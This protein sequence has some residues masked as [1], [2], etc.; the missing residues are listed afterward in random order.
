MAGD[1]FGAIADPTRR[2]VF[3][4][5]ANA[6]P[7]TATALAADMEISRQAVAK[8]L[9]VL[10]DAGMAAGHRVGRETRYEARVEALGDIQ[11]WISDIEGQWAAR[12]EALAASLQPPAN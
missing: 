9:G 5:L 3:K 7:Q 4:T 11:R 2:H 1:V 6:G 12:L 8:H 10:S